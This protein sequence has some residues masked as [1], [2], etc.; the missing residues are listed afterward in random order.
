MSHAWSRGGLR[1]AE[2]EFRRIRFSPV[3]G[4]MLTKCPS[5]IGFAYSPR[6]V[7][8]G[9]LH[10]QALGVPEHA[11]PS[12]IETGKA[13]N[14]R[15]SRLLRKAFGLSGWMPM[16]RA[17]GRGHRIPQALWHQTGA[18]GL[19]HDFSGLRCYAFRPLPG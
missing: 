18:A 15:L 3:L 2:C 8:F 1:S 17:R 5:G 11:G 13:R 6:G 4:E 7:T 12:V 19:R 16:P 9:R 14:P 10:V